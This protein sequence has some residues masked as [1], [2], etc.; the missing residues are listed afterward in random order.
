MG[1]ELDSLARTLLN[2]AAGVTTALDL[3]LKLGLALA[4]L[5]IPNAWEPCCPLVGSRFSEKIK[6]DVGGSSAG[7]ASRS[8]CQKVSIHDS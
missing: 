8:Q 1:R 4:L 2:K 5:D 7:R 6:P 3:E